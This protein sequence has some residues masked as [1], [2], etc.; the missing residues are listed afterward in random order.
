IILPVL[1]WVASI[2]TF[3]YSAILFFKTFTGKFQP[4]KLSFRKVQEAPFG[5]LLSPMILWLLVVIFG[6]FHNVIVY[7]L[8]DLAM[9]SILP[10]VI[11]PREK[12]NVLISHWH[13]FNLALFMTVGV[14]SIGI[15]LLIT[16][17]KWTRTTFYQNEQDMMNYVYDGGYDGL[18]K[19]SQV[20]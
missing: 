10:G 13:G 9:S 19:G 4:E 12:F 14:I 16:M 6:L 2:F 1:A 3:L 20:L 17:K 7:T 11:E 15:I 8:I 5:M 18:I